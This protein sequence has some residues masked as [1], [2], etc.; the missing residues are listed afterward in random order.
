MNKKL[1]SG[2]QNTAHQPEGFLFKAL[3]PGQ[4]RYF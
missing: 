4:G 3:R 1:T 2:D